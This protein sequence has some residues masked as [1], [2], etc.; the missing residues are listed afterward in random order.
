[1]YL[2]IHRFANLRPETR[3]KL[4]EK[5][6]AFRRRERFH[7]LLLVCQADAQGVGGTMRA[8]PQLAGWEYLLAECDKIQARELLSQGFEGIQLKQELHQRR[9]ACAKL[10]ESMR[11]KNEK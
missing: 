6:D 3:V 8:Y 1:M 4:L 7:D 11:I 5:T 10:I 2:N 9:V